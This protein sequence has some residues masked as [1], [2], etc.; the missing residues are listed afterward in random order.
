MSSTL[1]RSAKG[2]PKTD[3]EPESSGIPPTDP[4]SESISGTYT[5]WIVQ[6][7][8][9][10]RLIVRVPGLHGRISYGRSPSRSGAEVRFYRTQTAKSYAAVIPDVAAIY[11]SD[12]SI[13]SSP[14]TAAD[15]AK[16]E[17]QQAIEQ[18]RIER[19]TEAIV[20]RTFEEEVSY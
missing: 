14:K 2:I 4:S 18:L 9:E 5:E 8:D 17:V 3:A 20:K 15:I 10:Q 13:E 6:L 1:S 7:S 11:A 16:D 12:V 19:V